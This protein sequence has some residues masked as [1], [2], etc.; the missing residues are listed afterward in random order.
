MFKPQ[1]FN[2][3]KHGFV[4]CSNGD[5]YAFGDNLRGECGMQ[6]NTKGLDQCILNDSDIK[7]ISVGNG[8]TYLY[9]HDGT[10]LRAGCR[11]L[12]FESKFT[13]TLKDP[14]IRDIVCGQDLD[15]LI[16]DNGQVLC[17]GSYFHKVPLCPDITSKKMYFIVPA[18]KSRLAEDWHIITVLSQVVAIFPVENQTYFYTKSNEVYLFDLKVSNQLIKLTTIENLKGV[19]MSGGL[20]YVW[21]NNVL[22]VAHSIEYPDDRLKVYESKDILYITAS[23][24]NI[25]VTLDDNSIY[26]LRL[27]D[28]STMDVTKIDSDINGFYLYGSKL[29][30]LKSRKLDF[31]SEFEEI[32][33]FE[34]TNLVSNLFSVLDSTSARNIDFTSIRKILFPLFP[35]DDVWPQ[36][37][38]EDTSVKIIGAGTYEPQINLR[39]KNFYSLESRKFILY[40]YWILKNKSKCP[41]YIKYKITEYA[42]I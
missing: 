40:V 18:E 5:L 41:K 38:D 16:K 20:V 19:F 35:K 17:S 36:Y 30:T 34:L 12:S 2:D 3:A 27:N 29:L 7:K 23:P 1:L 28:K 37:Y 24:F 25:L 13:I 42:I 10:L 15:F 26:S 14:T 31:E 39:Y 33:C 32:N 9:R 4:Y 21:H 22:E 8:I 6:T 11:T